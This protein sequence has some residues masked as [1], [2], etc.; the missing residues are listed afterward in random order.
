M[1][2]L[3]CRPG[4]LFVT[5]TGCSQ[6]SLARLLP[7]PS[8]SGPYL[9]LAKVPEQMLRSHHSGPSLSHSPVVTVSA[10]WACWLTISQRPRQTASSLCLRARSKAIG[11]EQVHSFRDCPDPAGAASHAGL[12]SIPSLH[13]HRLRPFV[14]HGYIHQ[15]VPRP[16]LEAGLRRLPRP[17]R[18]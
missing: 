6:G 13:W 18:D 9:E 5:P 4:P 12:F 8:T 16:W 15:P 14:C 17:P 1:G 3:G 10:R 2:S 11:L 7:A